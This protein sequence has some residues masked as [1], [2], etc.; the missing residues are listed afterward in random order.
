MRS[1]NFIPAISNILY[2][3][4]PNH[5]SVVVAGHY[6]LAEHMQELSAES[7]AE[8]ASFEF[9]VRFL[10]EASRRGHRSQ[11]ILWV[12]DIGISTDARAAIKSNYELP[13]SYQ[14]VLEDVPV[15]GEDLTVIFESSMRNKASTLLRKLYK[16]QP[17]LF[18]KVSAR[19]GDLVRCVQ[20]TECEKESRVASAAYV[21]PG[22]DAERL[23]VKEGPN[24]KCNLILATFF[25]ELQQRFSHKL[26]L[27]VF[28]C[29]YKYRLQLGIHVSRSILENPTPFF[30]IFCDG[31]EFLFEPPT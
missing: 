30:N 10:A 25:K 28:N 21:V 7:E 22:P 15:E 4:P 12:N 14:R 5:P 29:V 11:L 31:D 1:E 3:V 2:T 24:P 9:G 8:L 27:N 19:R 20:N 23:V 16:R 13:E 17:Y 18:E 26:Q 6:C